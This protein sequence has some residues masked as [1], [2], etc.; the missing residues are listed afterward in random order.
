MLLGD[1]AER[2]EIGDSSVGE[3]DIDPALLLPHCG[4][5]PV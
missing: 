1:L 3:Q 5:E 4:I 2:S